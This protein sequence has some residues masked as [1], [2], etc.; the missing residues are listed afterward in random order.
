M[1][2][3]KITKD[4]GKGR[5]HHHHGVVV[6]TPDLTITTTSENDAKLVQD[7]STDRAHFQGRFRATAFGDFK[8]KPGRADEQS[9]AS[10]DDYVFEQAKEEAAL[11]AA[12]VV[13]AAAADGVVVE[14]NETGERG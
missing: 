9:E 1:N 3:P 13:E 12:A 8:H 4:N 11:A 5:H 7:R 14:D 6:Y 10:Q 2:G